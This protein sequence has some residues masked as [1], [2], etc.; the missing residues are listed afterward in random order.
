MSS[1]IGI[2]ILII[3]LLTIAFLLYIVFEEKENEH[4]SKAFDRGKRKNKRYFT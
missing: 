3:F 4:F 1:L 2:L